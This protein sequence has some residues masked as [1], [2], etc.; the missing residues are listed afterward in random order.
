ML[1]LLIEGMY[2]IEMASCGMIYL[3]LPRIMKM[4]TGVQAILWFASEM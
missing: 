2:A 1:V 4:S 3:Y